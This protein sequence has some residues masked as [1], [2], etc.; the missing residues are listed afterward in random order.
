MISK[1][2]SISVAVVSLATSAAVAASLTER[3]GTERMTIVRVDRAQHRFLCAEHR[4]WTRISK[5][6]VAVLASGDIITVHRQE[7][8]LPR[9]K[10]VRT[11]AEE[12]ASPER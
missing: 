12:L 7:A 10:V 8:G 4:H 11:A 6:D 2:L 5:T 1:V 3:M 9:V